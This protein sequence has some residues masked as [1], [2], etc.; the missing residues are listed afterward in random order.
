MRVLSIILLICLFISSCK[1]ADNLAFVNQYGREDFSA[2]RNT[3]FFVRGY[4]S[5][6]NIILFASDDFEN[7]HRNGLVIMNVDPTTFAVNQFDFKL[8][9][10]R[11][12]SEVDQQKLRHLARRF[13]NFPIWRLDV[14]RNDNVFVRL[15]EEDKP[16]LARFSDAKYLT[17]A[18]K[19][20]SNWKQLKGNWYV[21]A[22]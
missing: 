6:R 20:Q 13:M 15:Q 22:L 1:Q 4:D 3:T 9:R 21:A 2:F 19:F 12:S 11:D 10:H 18:G 14:D 8:I 17:T 5:Q 16:A 7:T